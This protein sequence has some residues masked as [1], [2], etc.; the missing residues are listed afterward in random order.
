MCP[1][2]KRLTRVACFFNIMYMGMTHKG[3]LRKF[4]GKAKE[5]K[6]VGDSSMQECI[7]SLEANHFENAVDGGYFDP[8]S[9]F[10]YERML[11]DMKET[12]R[13]VLEIFEVNSMSSCNT[14][15]LLHHL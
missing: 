13:S 2:K 4:K 8:H 3:V 1:F 7:E 15:Q 12:F 10:Q 9:F 6:E 11:K 5:R 14:N